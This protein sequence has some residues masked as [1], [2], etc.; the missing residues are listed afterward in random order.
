METVHTLIE[1]FRL[2]LLQ[3]VAFL[4]RLAVALVIVAI[5][6]VLAK[7]AKLAVV[8]ALRAVNFNVLT[9]RAGLDGFLRQGGIET[10]TSAI[11]GL[12]AFWMVVLGA[13]V[14]AFN[15]MNFPYVSDFLSRAVF[16]IPRLAVALLIA[17]LGAYFARFVA[18]AVATYCRQREIPDADML[19]SLA[20]Y[21]ILIFV[22]LIAFDHTGIGGDLMRESFLIVL[23][24]MVFALAL[25]FGLGG[26]RAAA[27]VLDRWWPDRN[28]EGR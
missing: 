16:Y 14:A 21:A 27:R 2:M 20:Q 12:L 8:K 19:G 15:A 1:P 3:I 25:A 6:W 10:D 18:N 24:G 5:G 7:M 17:T 9:E 26:R 13:L 22:I 4:P 23:A 28:R 11:F